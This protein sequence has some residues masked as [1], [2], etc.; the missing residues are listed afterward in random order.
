MPKRRARPKKK[1]NRKMIVSEFLKSSV[2][3]SETAT[4]T[5]DEDM[6]EETESSSNRVVAQVGGTMVDALEIPSPPLAEKVVRF[7][8]EKKTLE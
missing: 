1:A 7:K 6:R 4:S 2:A 5:T 3:M 8:V